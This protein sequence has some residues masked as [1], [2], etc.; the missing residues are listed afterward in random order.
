MSGHSKWANIKHRKGLVDA[1]KGI[2]FTKLARELIV[3]T[4]QGGGGDP[5]ANY[6][7]RL[8]IDKARQ[9]NMP[10]ENI[11]R[12]I[13]KGLGTGEGASLEETTYEGYAPGGAAILL[14][15]LTDNRN[16]TASEV[17]TVFT[18]SGGSLGELGSVTWVFENKAVVTVEGLGPE[19]AEE[20]ALAVIDAGADDFRVEDGMLEV[21]GPPTALDIMQE[22]MRESGAKITKAELAM[23]PKTTISLD[24]DHA[25][26]TLRLLDKLD[27]LEDVSQ[28]FTNADFPDVALEKYRQE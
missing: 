5:T 23:V 28:V 3:A 26:Q 2:V 9:S 22:T 6:R 7:L 17:R 15:A 10:H 8:A 1:K 18:R 24:E 20:L 4:R 14:H 13:K 12:A 27:D 25:L 21:V 11:D 19:Q 16:R